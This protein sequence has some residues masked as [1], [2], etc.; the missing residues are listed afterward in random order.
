MADEEPKPLAYIPE[1][2]LKKRKSNEEWA[3]K[4]RQQLEERN[5]R[6]KQNKAFNLKTA[7]QYIQ[8]YRNR[9]ER[10]GLWSR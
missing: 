2:I 9:G 1:V 4:R 7:E 10:W 5:L 3:I 6:S 8:E